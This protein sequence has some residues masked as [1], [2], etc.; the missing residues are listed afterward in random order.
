MS[1]SPQK[2]PNFIV[3]FLRFI[4]GTISLSYKKPVWIEKFPGG[5]K[6]FFTAPARI[7]S[8]L[9]KKAGAFKEKHR[10]VFWVISGGTGVLIAGGIAFLIVLSLLPKPVT[11]SVSVTPPPVT[12]YATETEPRVHPLT[13]DFEGSVAKLEDV[14]NYIETGVKLEPAFEGKWKWTSE[15]RITFM[16]DHDWPVAAEYTVRLEKTL[17]PEHILLSGYELKFQTAPFSVN[18]LKC[19]FYLDPV[20][21]AN[22]QIVATLNF[23]HPVNTVEFEKSVSIRP[24]DPEN[25]PA[26]FTDKNY[27]S[28]ITFDNNLC[29]AYIS[30]D[31]LPVPQED[32]VMNLSTGAAGAFHAQAGGPSFALEQTLRVSI[33]GYVSFIKINSIEIAMVRNEKYIYDQILVINSTGET[34]QD[35]ISRFMRVY[36]LPKDRPEK[37]GQKASR[38]HYWELGEIDPSVLNAS[39]RIEMQPLPTERKWVSLNSYRFEAPPGRLIYVELKKNMP[40]YGDYILANDVKKILTTKDAPKEIAILSEGAILSLS[41]DKKLSLLANNVSRV[42][43]EIGRVIPDQI[44]HLVSQT[45]GDFKNPY[46]RSS[47][48]GENNITEKY[49]EVRSLKDDGSGKVKFFS[50]DFTPYLTRGTSP[51]MRHGLFFFHIAEERAS[52][53]ETSR[54]S[55]TED[56]YWDDEDD[57]EYNY[58]SNSKLRLSRFIL[59]TDL[60]MVVK[61]SVTGGYDVFVVSISTGLPVSNAVVEILG[62]NGISVLTRSTDANGQAAFLSVKG[63]VNEK[64]PVAF[65][66]RKGEDL[67]FIPFD[68]SDR[69]INFSRFDTGGLYGESDPKKL[70]AFIFSDRGL[71]RPGDTFHTGIIIKTRDWL[72]IPEGLP[73]EAVIVDPRGMEISRQKIVLSKTAFH[74]IEYTLK[75][76]APTGLY[77]TDLYIIKDNQARSLIGTNSVQVQEFLPDKML[78]SARFLD[79]ENKAWVSPQNLKVRLA[80]KNLYG[81]PASGNT[82]RAQYR[83]SPHYWSFPEYSAYEFTD[84]LKPD[85]ELTEE[86]VDGK[87]NEM[88]FA[89]FAIDLSRFREASYDVRFM[90]QAL[91]KEGGRSVNTETFV[92]V[93]PLEYMVGYRVDGSLSYIS[94]GSEREAELIAVNALLKKVPVSGLKM[95]LTSLRWVSVL[96]KQPNGTFKYQSVEKRETVSE[97][98]LSLPAAGFTFKLPT[99]EPGDYELAVYNK[100]E[101]KLCQ[102]KFTVVGEANIRRSLDRNAELQVKLRKYDYDPGEEIEIFINAPY[103]GSGLITVERDR[104]Y[105]ARWFKTVTTSSVQKIRVPQELEGNAYVNVSFVRAFDSNEIYMSPLSYGVVPFSISR[106]RRI[107]SIKLDAVPEAR[108]GEPLNILFSADK[109]GKIVV[110]AVDTG[111]L[112]VAGYRLPNPLL[113]FFKKQALEVTTTQI[114]DL[115]LPEFRLMQAMSP[116][117]GGEGEDELSRNLN[118][119]KR[120]RNKPVV[121]WSGI[122]D[123]DQNPRTVSYPVPDYFNGT[124][125]I[126]ALAVNSDSVGVISR[127]TLIRD[128]F[129][130][131]PN[132]PLFALPGDTI[133]VGVNVTNNVPGS[134]K[135]ASVTLDL[136]TSPGVE[137][138]SKPRQVLEIP[139]GGD[140]TTKY[141]VRIKEI[142]GNADFSF[143]A[144]RGKYTSRITNSLS[145]RP[146]MPYRTELSSGVLKK[147][148]INIPIRRKMYDEFHTSKATVSFVPLGLSTGLVHYL[149]NF[150]YGCTEQIISQSFPYIILSDRPELGYSVKEALE[151]LKNV[152]SILRV[153]QLS[154]GSIGMWA[155]ND[156]KEEFH[157]VYAM[158]YLTEAEEAGLPV[159]VDLDVSLLNYLESLM[160]ER[161]YDLS[162]RLQAFTVYILTRNGIVTTSYISRLVNDLKRDNGWKQDITGVMLAGAYKLLKQD[163]EAKKLL[164]SL[165]PLAKRE[166]DAFYSDLFM[167]SLVLYIYARHFP[168]ELKGISADLIT[169]ITGEVLSNDY[170]TFSAA[171]ATLALDAYIQTSGTPEKGAVQLS[172]LYSKDQVKDL[173]LPV[174]I[175][176]RVDFD[177][178]ASSLRIRNQRELPLF[179]QAIQAGFDKSVPKDPVKQRMEVQKIYKNMEGNP[180][181][182]I[183]LGEELEVHILLRV[184]DPQISTVPNIAVVDLLPGGFEMD[185]AALNSRYPPEKHIQNSE[186][187][188]VFRD[189]R[190]DRIVLYGTIS[191]N[192]AEYVYWI[193]AVNEGQ[194]NVPPVFAESMYDKTI[195]ALMPGE[196][197][198]VIPLNS[199]G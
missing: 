190:E 76:T 137:I 3:R 92:L 66:V 105:A 106:G 73:L 16:P 12:I 64:K 159:P 24:S 115:I 116:Y 172:E 120:R 126:M 53:D 97:T 11:V 75:E 46:F 47:R 34:S 61:K 72:P 48:F 122:M 90:A 123:V 169:R 67:S 149:D 119:F 132:V 63:F 142:L 26:N 82:V 109:P 118:P 89:D 71:Y 100:K 70:S 111:I 22:K 69:V 162:P 148:D 2:K 108:P 134:G 44:N 103:T 158:Q 141:R 33:P 42:R 85:R 29:T 102:F 95:N 18:I 14:G 179:Y 80:L 145:V 38:N 195:W 136:Q 55:S 45:G 154:D 56:E 99:E 98:P 150:P 114:L 187:D 127:S 31:R 94:R 7:F 28:K 138:L 197:L 40:F 9:V 74:E 186:F 174:G 39:T 171:Y 110:W 139:E 155:A 30:T 20:D 164:G 191:N 62:E 181:T 167:D 193:K 180:V 23:S 133:T 188:P 147:G 178:S 130:I 60:A 37:P 91:E 57:Y 27:V 25:L 32:V 79:T 4:F 170:N 151:S 152:I 185:L 52:E 36:L 129:V 101:T 198:K 96:T 21:P 65:L 88:G 168:S 143:K 128:Y 113:H 87:T 81:T 125:K 146:P 8:N 49:T 117:G 43:F 51:R 1:D 173:V 163:D 86:L 194:T 54:N 184:I 104:V 58:Y 84:P 6:R 183:K 121:F 112:Q 144:S 199:G 189:A 135:K 50:F 13:I 41:G 161:Y 157:T 15:R 175:F 35:N 153:R 131:N 17:F 77:K 59:V 83:L 182:E 156:I 177:P 93:S 19:E 5:V 165:A 124:L 140:V 107:T 196:T 176:P 10:I 160:E 166:G 68:A 78:C 192:I